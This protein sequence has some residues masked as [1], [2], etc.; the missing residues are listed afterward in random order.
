MSEFPNQANASLF[1]KPVHQNNPGS[2]QIRVEGIMPSPQPTSATDATTKS[3]TQY[4]SPEAQAR[5]NKLGMVL[6]E[7]ANLPLWVQQVIYTDL[8]SHLEK[9]AGLYR[10]SAVSRDDFL[11]LWKPT[12]TARGQDALRTLTLNEHGDTLLLLD[13]IRHQDNIAMMC[14]R[15]EWSLQ[16]A[17]HLLIK[18]L[19][20]Q[21]IHPPHSKILEASIRFL[22][23]EIR[24][25]E[26]LVFIG[27]VD[28][29]QME[30]ALQTQE[31]IESAMGE[32]A[33]IADI[34]IRLE[35]LTPE[36]VQSILFLK[37]ESCKPFRLF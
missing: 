12:L 31:Y 13:A 7:M 6:S 9:D 18:A 22:G 28:R 5:A 36:D 20:E 17:C 25:G 21:Y 34:L 29:T 24:I 16:N 30:L 23:D 8:K 35:I 19:R 37:E 33:R 15:Y 26:Y 14:A 27:R 3:Q 4:N 1:Q 10:L 11:Q 2:T 32:R